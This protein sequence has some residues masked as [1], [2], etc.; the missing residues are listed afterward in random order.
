MIEQ[1]AFG[2]RAKE[3]RR[4]RSLSQEDV[5]GGD[6][7]PSY[8]SL[9]ESGRRIPSVRAAGV[10]A[11][12]LGVALDELC[13]PEPREQA[14]SNR[15]ELVGQLVAARSCHLAGD[16]RL[17]RAQLETFLEN[18]VGTGVEE[19]RWEA[20]WEL[21]TVL[22]KLHE[23]EG[24]ERMLKAL[25][26]DQI[27]VSAPLLRARVNT[28]LAVMLKNTG[29]LTEAVAPAE[30]AVRDTGGLEGT[31]AEHIQARVTL[32]SVYTDT[33]EWHRNHELGEELYRHADGLPEGRLKATLFWAVGGSRYLERHPDDARGLLARAA[34]SL[35][36]Q[37]DPAT[38]TRL[39]SARVLLAHATGH[40]G[41]ARE[42]LEA[43]RHDME[44]TDP[45]DRA[46]LTVLGLTLGVPVPG[47]D[48][49]TDSDPRED[50][51]VLP[52]LD[53]ARCTMLLARARRTAGTADTAVTAEAAFRDAA[54]RYEKAGA[55][56]L[57]MAAWRELEDG[58]DASGTDAGGEPV[59]GKATEPDAHSLLMP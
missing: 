31:R 5:A 13:A 33:G 2:Q 1:P 26:A 35:G 38:R 27:T 45:T 56:R 41:E 10:I 4:S 49:R 36:T 11:E 52:P 40:T 16:L 7:S 34:E 30:E 15:I 20:L 54:A 53:R 3:I 37:A 32:L 57:A 6:I 24:H 22:G 47:A 12:R 29:R 43:H 59:T 44:S 58:T 25:L 9:V 21:A 55:Y 19:L 39:T 48:G 28:E 51:S 8:V 46:W 14:R 17:A 18:A 50:W 23:A 42:L